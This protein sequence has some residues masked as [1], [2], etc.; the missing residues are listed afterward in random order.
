MHI[1]KKEVGGEE[2]VGRYDACTFLF[3]S[4]FFS[5]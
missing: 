2:E 4:G 3:R 5:V 1:D